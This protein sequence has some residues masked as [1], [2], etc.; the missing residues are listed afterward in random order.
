MSDIEY[1]YARLSERL[2]ERPDESAWRRIESI[3][4]FAALL[5]VAR[6]GA[7]A[8]WTTGIAH[9]SDPHAIDAVFRGHWR[10][11]VD[12]VAR[13]MPEP[14][15]PAVRWVVTLADLPVIEHL[16]RQHAA[17]AWFASDPVYRDF[18]TES[19]A[20]C[21]T[22]LATGAMAPLLP[23]W[24]DPD[25]LLAVWHEAFVAQLP[26][27]DDETRAHLA[28]LERALT[29]HRRAI[30][31]PTVRDAWPLRRALQARLLH[32]FRHTLVEPVE[33]FIYLALVALDLE[34]LRGEL[35]RRAAFPRGSALP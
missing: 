22:A 14:W 19:E 10:A 34:R 35:V 31:E 24:R 33:A 11:L 15:Q 5:D 3:R 20:A 32:L 29:D 2:G 30:G 25:R 23:A 7:H 1:A 17:P 6:I 18:V 12:E 26:R 13:W 16:A 21:P 8:R 27:M 4:D 9:D 28:A